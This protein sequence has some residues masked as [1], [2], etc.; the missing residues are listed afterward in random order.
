VLAGAGVRGGIAFG[1]SDKDAAWPID[2]PV[3]PEDLSCTI[4]DALGIDPHAHLLKDRQE[5]PTAL[6][7]GGRSLTE[8]L[9]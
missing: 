4:Y 8:L 1:R 3:S 6:V 7:D 9:A 5:R 2:Q